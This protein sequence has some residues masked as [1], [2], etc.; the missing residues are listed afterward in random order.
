MVVG[1][2][3]IRGLTT[4]AGLWSCAC[5]GLAIGIGFYEGAIISCVV[6]ILHRL[7]MYSRTHSKELDIYVELQDIAG[8]SNFINEVKS[9][10]TF[11]KSL[12]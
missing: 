12:D 11:K 10:G 2:N 5:M 3:Q 6:T 9:D 1:R 4:A 8:V 7:D